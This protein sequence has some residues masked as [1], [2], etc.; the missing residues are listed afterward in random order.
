MSIFL[1]T[2]ASVWGLC[3]VLDTGFG[4]MVFDIHG[5]CSLAYV[6]LSMVEIGP[7][8]KSI[9]ANSVGSQG[10]G[11]RGRRRRSSRVVSSRIDQ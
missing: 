11:N 7:P 10:S 3:Q 8:Y 2:G 6:K 1:G 4:E 9:K 5:N